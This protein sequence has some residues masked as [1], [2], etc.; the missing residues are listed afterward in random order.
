MDLQFFA[1][2]ALAVTFAGVS[3][4][5]FGGGP[6]F[7]ASAILALVAT[8]TQAIGLMLPLLML[9]DVTA[10]RPFWKK[11]DWV[12]AKIMIIGAVPGVAL[13][14]VF[15]KITNDDV[16]RLLI[17]LVSLGFVVWQLWPK[18]RVKEANFSAPVG[19]IAGL[20]A[21]FT[22]FI[23]HAGGPPGA[24]YLLS[25]KLDKTTY[26]ATMT[27]IFWIVNMVKVIPYAFLGIF[28]F[29]TVFNGILLAPFAIIGVWLGVRAH[30]VLSEVVF[31]RLTYALLAMT[32]GKLI[33]DALT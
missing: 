33:F 6:A 21:G 15:Y 18:T 25:Q 3:K 27:L 31:F 13:G 4:G 23:S 22:S 1:V 19:L 8:P 32:G 16:L 17:G 11:W 20:V 5:G 12:R 9:M 24:M 2:A 29:D 7:A 28:T 10:L 14:A 30:Y 26:H